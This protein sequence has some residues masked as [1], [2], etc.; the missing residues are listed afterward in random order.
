MINSDISRR[1]FLALASA[2][3]VSG[4]APSLATAQAQMPAR[5]IPGTNE[6]LPI[7]G[8]GSSKVVTGVAENGVQPLEAVLDALVTEGGSV[9]DTWPRNADND[10][11]FGQ[12]INS[13][14]L[15][16]RLFITTKIDQE[17]KQAGIDQFE[18][19]LELYQRDAVDLV[20]IFSLTDLDVQWPNLRDWKE[21]G[22]ARYIGVTVSG[23]EL[24]SQLESFLQREQPD[25][26][27]I[28]YSIVE[29][30]AEERFLPMA[31]D[32]GIAVLINR[33]FMNGSYFRRLENTELPD[34]TSEFDCQSWAQF[35][36]KY[37]L[38]HPAITCVLT[39]TS[40]P[41]HMTEN[42]ITASS[43]LPDEAARLRMSEY[44][45]QV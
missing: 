22:K 40:N 9:V 11:A 28:N 34:W 25:F 37:I 38:A 33:P 21:S 14:N 24:Y 45:D 42:A 18:Q 31:A 3:G 5:L 4:L 12:V 35:S 26:I 6:S 20:Q 30:L 7:V 16:D 39:E 44:I 23:E 36:L 10:G 15:K 41:A 32:R 2:A 13:D 1:N 29:R 8:L 43:A 27:Q 17:G 19:T